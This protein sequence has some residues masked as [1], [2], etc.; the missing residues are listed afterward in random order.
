MIVLGIH[1]NVRCRA[2]FSQMLSIL[3]EDPTNYLSLC[4]KMQYAS[5]IT[6]HTPVEKKSDPDK[7]IKNVNLWYD[8][9]LLLLPSFTG[10][11]HN[12][13]AIVTVAACY[14]GSSGQLD[15][16]CLVTCSAIYL[17][18]RLLS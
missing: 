3:Y 4:T 9:V 7:F 15:F 17:F 1:L 12:Q 6:R 18:P 2:S 11:Q 8:Y 5:I 14:F 10:Q 16:G 13:V